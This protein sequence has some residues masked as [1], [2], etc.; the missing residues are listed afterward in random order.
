[1]Q[2]SL[3]EVAFFLDYQFVSEE[4]TGYTPLSWR[5]AGNAEPG[6]HTMTVNISGLW[7]QVG[8]GT[9]KFLVKE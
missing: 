9:V 8:V 6:L 4:E 5:W 1:M 3:Y 2:Q 7:G